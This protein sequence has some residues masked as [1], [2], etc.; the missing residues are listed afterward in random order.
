MASV[1]KRRMEVRCGILH[2]AGKEDCEQFFF[3]EHSPYSHYLSFS[4][5]SSFFF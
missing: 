3:T 1:H 5:H 4:G 2:V